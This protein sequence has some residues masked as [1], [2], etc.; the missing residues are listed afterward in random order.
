MLEFK[1]YLHND[2]NFIINIVLWTF[3]PYPDVKYYDS[4]QYRE[5]KSHCI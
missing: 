2:E 5:S 1:I 3:F 4:N